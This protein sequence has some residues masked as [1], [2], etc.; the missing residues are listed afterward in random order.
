MN[1]KKNSKLI[2]AENLSVFIKKILSKEN[3]DPISATNVAEGLVHASIRGV[4]SHGIRLLPHYLRGLEGGRINGNP[5]YNFEK[6]TSTTGILDAD[7]AFGHAAGMRAVKHLIELTKES[8]M[9]SVSVRHSTHFGAASFFGLEI[10]RHG[11]LGFSFTHSDPLIPPSGGKKPFLGNNPICFTCPVE[12][13][14]PLCVD[15]A[16]SMI[17]FNKVL[18]MREDKLVAPNGVGYD[19]EGSVTTDPEKI[20]SLAPV[21]GYKGYGLS[22]MVEILC[23]TLSGMPIAPNIGHMYKDGP[24]KKRNLGHFFMAINIES[25]LGLHSFN[26]RMKD[27]INE[28]RMQ[29]PTNINAPIMVAGDP[30]K[31]TE[32]ERA[33]NGIPVGSH[34]IAFLEELALKYGIKI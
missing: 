1:N 18:R 6:T 15:M 16:T 23:A 13:E 24:D 2:A 34:E 3:V 25:F 21:G 8:G 30:E 32:N 20:I 27:I 33:Q 7:N 26:R 9:G 17:T 19:S 4:D 22:L 14:G 12:G 29:E 11:M 5:V 28:L 10:A 31:K